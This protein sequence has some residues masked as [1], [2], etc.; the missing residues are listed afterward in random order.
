LQ[1]LESNQVRVPIETK[2]TYVSS[3]RMIEMDF[4]SNNSLGGNNFEV[5]YRASKALEFEVGM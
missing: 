3:E 4:I 1:V 2:T 5:Q